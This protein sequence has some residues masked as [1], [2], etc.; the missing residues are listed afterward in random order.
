MPYL[1]TDA[2]L[3]RALEPEDLDFIYRIE[4]DRSF[5]EIGTDNI[6]Y[7]RYALR[8]YL[9]GQPQDI[10]Q[11]GQLRLIVHL[12]ENQQDIGIV[13]LTNFSSTDRRAEVGILLIKE[14]QGRGL[15]YVVLD[16]LETYAVNVLHLHQLY[17]YVSKDNNP[18]S[19][20]LFRKCGYTASAELLDWHFYHGKYE[21]ALLFQKIL[22]KKP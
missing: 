2:V 21:T 15:G 19:V 13:D 11:C 9:A 8:E 17:A 22:Q 6:P 16:L 5:W 3:L 18:R 1:E 14:M 12:K 20:A 10:F 4:N 7:S